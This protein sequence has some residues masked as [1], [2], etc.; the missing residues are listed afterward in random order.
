MSLLFTTLI[1][2]WRDWNRHTWCSLHAR[3]TCLKSI[4][5]W[6][7]WNIKSCA[8]GIVNKLSWSFWG[9]SLIKV[10]NTILVYYWY[11]FAGGMYEDVASAQFEEGQPFQ[12]W[13]YRC[14]LHPL[15]AANCCCNS[16]LV[17]DGDDF[18]WFKNSRKWS[19]IGKPVSWK[20]SF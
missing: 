17:V 5:S 13:I 19:C 4:L 12:A 18:M 1:T 16:R 3:I 7:N 8:I 14:H 20:F 6:I 10:Y 2:S 9:L 11:F 15:Q